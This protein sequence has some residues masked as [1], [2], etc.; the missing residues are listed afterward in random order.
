MKQIPGRLWCDIGNYVGITSKKPLDVASYRLDEQDV[1][2]QDFFFTGRCE[3]KDGGTMDLKVSLMTSVLVWSCQFRP[4]RAGRHRYLLGNAWSCF[5][6]SRLV[7]SRLGWSS[8]VVARLA[9]PRL[10][11]SALFSFLLACLRRFSSGL[12]S[13]PP[14]FSPSSRLV[15]ALL[16]PLASS[17]L[18]SSFLASFRLVA[19]VSLGFVLSRLVPSLIKMCHA[20]SPCLNS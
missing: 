5:V 2:Q 15:S 20:E 3:M 16:L 6:S 10:F 9:W 1:D 7:S 17:L 13:P 12:P 14:L 19:L 4:V 8:F 18:R 11:S